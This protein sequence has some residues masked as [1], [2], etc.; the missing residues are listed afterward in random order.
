MIPTVVAV[1]VVG[2]PEYEAGFMRWLASY[3]KH[4]PSIKHRVVVIERYAT[5]STLAIPGFIYDAVRYDG[6]GWDCG[7]WQ[8][9]AKNL[10][11]ELLVCFNSTC[12]IM[13]AGWLERFV[14]AVDIHGPGLYGPM[15]SLEVA[16]HIR[17]P[18]MVFTPDVMNAYPGAVNSRDDTYRFESFGFG[19]L[20]NV[21]MW[22]KRQGKPVKMVTWS[23]AYD[24]LDCR[25]PPNVFR[26]GD[27]SDLIV[28]DK[29]AE[30]Y[31]ASN[32]SGKAYLE[33][34]TAK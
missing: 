10:N 20:P 21:S 9:A 24:L 32:P 14:D 11:A 31:E 7:A 2:K 15:A 6:H 27:Q 18:C 29:H 30:A 34:L 28:K 4:L 33:K 26:S 1:R 17:T 12:Q 23:G 3:W 19:D 13:G 22:T 16:P 25:K 5:G 8:F